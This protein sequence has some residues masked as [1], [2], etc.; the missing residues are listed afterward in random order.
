ML[1]MGD[2]CMN[3]RKHPQACSVL[4]LH[5]RPRVRE[6]GS[7]MTEP[8]SSDPAAG[9]PRDF[10]EAGSAG[11]RRPPTEWGAGA[12]AL[13][14]DIPQVLGWMR[15]AW[16]HSPAAITVTFGSRHLLIYQNEA[17]RALFGR[18]RTG[19]PIAEAFPDGDQNRVVELD[20]A[21]AERRVLVR[22]RRRAGVRDPQGRELHV[23]YVIV[24]YGPDGAPP[25]GLT[26]LTVDLTGEV[27]AELASNRAVLL[28]RLTERMIAAQDP[29]SAL[30]A[31]TDVLVPEL[32]DMAAVY[33]LPDQGR[34]LPGVPSGPEALS[35]SP[36]LR[37][38]GP[39][40][41]VSTRRATPSRWSELFQ[42]GRPLLLPFDED[43]REEVAPDPAVRSWLVA[44][45][46]RNLAVVPL[47]VAGR[48]I[49]AV[50]LVAAGERTPYAES[51]LAFLTDVAARAGVAVGQVRQHR[52]QAEVSRRLQ[53]GL[54][55]AAP[56]PVPGLYVA[57]R[58][59]AGAEDVAVGGDWWDV[60]VLGD[61]QVAIGV[62]D[63]AGR[64]VDA[65]MM[66][67]HARA[68]MRTAGLAGL[69][70]GRVL[71]LLDRQ[72]ADLI[73]SAGRGLGERPGGG[74]QF[75]TALH[76]V[77]DLATGLVRLA[78]AGH[79]PPLIQ[80]PGCRARPVPVIPG[81]PLGLGLGG[82]QE[83]TIRLPE[84]GA[85]LMF[86]DGLV[87]D[88]TRDLDLGLAELGAQL[89]TFADPDVEASLD[90]ILAAMGATSSQL[91][92]AAD[93]VA[94]VLVRRRV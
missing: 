78:G 24:P 16:E 23:R 62:G 46:A 9:A 30:Q 44:A 60:A 61:H 33:V 27:R 89:N 93:D 28:A 43:T 59:V 87:E 64:G 76:A 71:E 84:G 80:G 53:H 12:G 1:G 18:R 41:A 77:I 22:D 17:S 73:G 67:G 54:L 68:A 58:Y 4:T 49:G 38:L 74:P 21:L 14:V 94:A 66:M 3:T 40:P 7:R 72:L 20:V 37:A 47:A 57:A 35:V 92:I 45:G 52:L 85:L 29:G 86:T 63:V 32:A 2:Y 82:Y 90:K 42:A 11:Y 83:C 39:P 88:R 8:L 13:P 75:A 5:F 26:V 81:P 55:P 25:L 15:D 51:I 70:P 31:L 48:V 56:P 69:S 36:V 79:P 6:A 10:A 65:A 19:V 50:L 34:A 91:R